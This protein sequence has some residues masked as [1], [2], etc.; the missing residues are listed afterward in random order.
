[1]YRCVVMFVWYTLA[2]KNVLNQ[3][4]FMF[5][6]SNFTIMTWVFVFGTKIIIT[7]TK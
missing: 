5:S 7:V 3:V 6:F 4:F 1:M 2:F